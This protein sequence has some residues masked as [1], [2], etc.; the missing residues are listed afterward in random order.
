MSTDSPGT[1]SDAVNGQAIKQVLQAERAAEQAV[2][3]C[4]RQA[5]DIIRAAQTRAQRIAQRGDER[6]TLIH[7]RCAQWLAEQRRL[8]AAAEHRAQAEICNSQL[9]TVSI[10]SV[11][12]AL[13]ATLSGADKEFP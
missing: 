3:A 5:G 11:V 4:D 7:M 12:D 6:I 9:D 1:A 8:L 10:A 2:A 13:A